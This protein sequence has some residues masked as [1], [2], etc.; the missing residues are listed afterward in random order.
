MAAAPLPRRRPAM[1]GL[2]L[3]APQQP[4]PDRGW[5]RP[6]DEGG[7]GRLDLGERAPPCWDPLLQGSNLVRA[8]HGRRPLARA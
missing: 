6:E 2:G 1:S 5:A 7:N 8:P 4:E 3:A